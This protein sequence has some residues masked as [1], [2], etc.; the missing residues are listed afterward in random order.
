MPTVS[1]YISDE[2]FDNLR[3]KYP[4]LLMSELK[5]KINEFIKKNWEKI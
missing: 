3:R 2:N 5:N 1:F 4:R